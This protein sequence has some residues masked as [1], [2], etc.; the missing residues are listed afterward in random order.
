VADRHCALQRLKRGGLVGGTECERGGGVTGCRRRR[1]RKTSE[2]E[3]NDDGGG[4]VVMMIRE[5]RRRAAY[6]HSGGWMR[7]DCN[8][9][10][11]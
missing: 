10:R 5:E 4:G 2:V 11:E 9:N 8:R 3:A 7:V 1:S 6:V